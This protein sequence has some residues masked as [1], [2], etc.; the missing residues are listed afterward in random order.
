ME[1][2][3][4]P[5]PPEATEFL[6][7][8]A[9]EF[10]RELTTPG[11]AGPDLVH[12]AKLIAA[13]ERLPRVTSGLALQASRSMRSEY[14][15]FVIGLRLDDEALVLDSMESLL[16]EDGTDH[17]AQVFLRAEVDG[18]YQTDFSNVSDGLQRWASQWRMHVSSGTSFTDEADETD[19]TNEIGS[20]P[21]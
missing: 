6:W 16:G 21:E 14:G 7:N 13:L 20:N 15:A 1:Q 10:R 2:S 17:Q 9:Q 3:R 11:M 4:Y 19:W 12:A 8:L 18:R 5:L